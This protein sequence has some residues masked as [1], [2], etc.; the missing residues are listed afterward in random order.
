MISKQGDNKKKKQK[1]I[2]KKIMISQGYVDIFEEGPIPNSFPLP[3]Y[4][5]VQNIPDRTAKADKE[6]CDFYLQSSAI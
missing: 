4:G 2:L 5:K 1:T 3:G 6:M